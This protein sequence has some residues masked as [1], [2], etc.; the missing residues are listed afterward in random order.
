MTQIKITDVTNHD[1]E[2]MSRWQTGTLET[3]ETVGRWLDDDGAPVYDDC[4]EWRIEADAARLIGS[5]D[6][7]SDETQETTDL[8]LEAWAD[9]DRSTK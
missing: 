3:G 4:Q 2:G 5:D 7:D 1:E 8:L 9:W 6:E